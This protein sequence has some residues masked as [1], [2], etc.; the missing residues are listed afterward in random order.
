MEEAKG[1]LKRKLKE[2]KKDRLH[3]YDFERMGQLT[4][5]LKKIRVNEQSNY[6]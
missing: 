3:T 2:F 1:L 6:Y 4:E 5:M